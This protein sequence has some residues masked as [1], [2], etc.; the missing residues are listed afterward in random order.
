MEDLLSRED[1]GASRTRAA[2]VTA[3]AITV[4][5]AAAAAP[6]ARTQ[7]LPDANQ[8]V[9]SMVDRQR[10]FEKALDEYTYDVLTTEE[11]L[12]DAGRARETHL[13]R[14]Q[15]FFVKGVPVRRLVEEDGRVLSGDRAEKEK[16]RALEA[17]GKA[18]SRK[19]S[20]KEEAESEVRLSEV[21][22]RFD[23]TAV[24]R[25]TVGGREAILVSFQAQPGKRAIK[26]DNVFRALQGRLWIDAEDHA[27]VRAQL[28]TK[29]P[30]KV[31]G[32]LIASVSRVDV[33]VDFVPVDAIWCP[34]RSR[35]LASG[36]VLFKSFRRS[37]SEEFS[38]YRRFV[39][40]TEET[41]IQ[42]RP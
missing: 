20:E 19:R 1:A 8:L 11:K 28:S 21:L 10:S 4:L 40:S 24:G 23:F 9:R 39:V 37:Y 29:Q 15:V 26:H 14:Y 30:I 42:P 38:N 32:G 31:G 5:L 18:R 41:P 33:D 17:A 34:R 6:P 7:D 12:D 25:E 36:R 2:A 16:K 35:S 22:A 13:R 27:V 3:A